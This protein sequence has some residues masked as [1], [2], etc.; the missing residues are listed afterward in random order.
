MKRKLLIG[1]L[2]VTSAIGIV[3]SGFSAW[4]F[5]ANTL[6]KSSNITTHT[7]NL[8][9]NIGTLT[10]NDKDK[11]LCVVLDQ[12]GDAT[13]TSKGISIVDAGNNTISDSNTGTKIDAFSVTYTI[14]A[15]SVTNLVNAGI[16]TALFHAYIILDGTAKNYIDFKSDYANLFPQKS[17][18]ISNGELLYMETVTFSANTAINKT[19]SFPASTN[20][21]G[22]N[23]MFVYNNK[24]STNVKYNSMKDALNGKTILHIE[25]GLTL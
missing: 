6:T 24:P 3:G 17:C 20:D 23:S 12:G 8:A 9:D 22:Q 11:K 14:D 7:T 19:F 4:Y 16:T 15:Q 25:Y 13:D 21:A 2:G 18:T 1:L 10:D 5:D